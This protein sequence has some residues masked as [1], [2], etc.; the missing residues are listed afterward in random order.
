MAAKRQFAD[1]RPLLQTLAGM[2]PKEK[3]NHLCTYYW[4]VLLVVIAVIM[5][6]SIIVTC[7]H[8]SRIQVLA[9]GYL[10]NISASEEGEQYLK[11]DFFQALGGD[12]KKQ[13][14]NL[15]SS[16]LDQ[17]SM[18]TVFMQ[19]AAMIAARELDY[20]MADES[21][22]ELLM[23]HNAFLPLESQMTPEQLAPWSDRLI[24]N[25]YLDDEG[26]EYAIAIDISDTPFARDCLSSA[27]SVYIAFP[28]NREDGLQ[29]SVIL[30][31]LLH[32]KN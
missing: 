25:T 23:N 6:I 26:A 30:E 4:W 17:T 13:A 3:L 14:V 11:D 28:G 24:Y 1:S 22:L 29:A 15:T 2:T 16:F 9:G 21:G 32:W 7:V 10:V 19:V 27:N 20:V 18:S 8:N 12:E 5:L 31:Y